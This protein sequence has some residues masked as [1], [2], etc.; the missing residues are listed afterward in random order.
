MLLLPVFTL[1]ARKPGPSLRSM[2]ML[3][4]SCARARS[5][6]ESTRFMSAG[7]PDA[8]G[9]DPAISKRSPPPKG[10]VAPFIPPGMACSSC[11][12]IFGTSCWPSFTFAVAC[13]PPRK[14]VSVTSSASL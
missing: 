3:T 6:S 2:R 12:E 14:Y 10:I 13:F 11:S 5:I 9:P 7:E 4:G 8:P 1:I